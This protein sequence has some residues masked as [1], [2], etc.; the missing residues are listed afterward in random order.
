VDVD[1]RQVDFVGMKLAR[2]QKL[3]H[4]SD[5]DLAGTSCACEGR[6]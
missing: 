4:L 2:L 5:A 3:L 6:R 1:A